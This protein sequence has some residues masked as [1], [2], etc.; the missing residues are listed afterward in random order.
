MTREVFHIPRQ[1]VEEIES[2]SKDGR[3][4][5]INRNVIFTFKKYLLSA[6]SSCIELASIELY[7]V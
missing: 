4:F 5:L 2:A 1:I 3:S 6:R 7:I